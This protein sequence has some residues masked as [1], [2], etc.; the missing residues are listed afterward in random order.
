MV[1]PN[2]CIDSH[3]NTK[4]YYQPITTMKRNRFD[5]LQVRSI[6]LRILIF[7]L[8]CLGQRSMRQGSSH[9]QKFCRKVVAN[10]WN[11]QNRDC[12][13]TAG[14]CFFKWRSHEHKNVCALNWQ[15]N[16]RSW[17]CEKNHQHFILS[18]RRILVHCTENFMVLEKENFMSTKVSVTIPL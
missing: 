14:S 17:K 11:Q 5:M 8:K 10:K 2:I 6:A 13:R 3:L 15:S 18:Q 9:F 4:F 12:D 16:N 7:C 1:Y